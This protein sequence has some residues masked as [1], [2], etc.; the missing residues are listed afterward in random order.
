ML[1]APAQ[2]DIWTQVPRLHYNEF[3]VNNA[4]HFSHFTHICEKEAE[5]R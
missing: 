3:K 5:N 1:S 2:I 4:K